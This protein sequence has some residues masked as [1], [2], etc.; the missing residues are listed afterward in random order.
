M[1][2]PDAP[3]VRAVQRPCLAKK[4]SINKSDFSDDEWDP[5]GGAIKRPKKLIESEANDNS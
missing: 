5:L 2:L 3:R 1:H 4:P